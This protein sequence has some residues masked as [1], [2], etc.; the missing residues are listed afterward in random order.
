MNWDK[1]EMNWDKF[2]MILKVL[3]S[4]LLNVAPVAY[5]TT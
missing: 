2:E 1:F 3:A 4:Y 5:S